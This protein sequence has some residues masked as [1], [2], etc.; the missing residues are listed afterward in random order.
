MMK[1]ETAGNKSATLSIGSNEVTISGEVL[2][3][4]EV[5]NLKILVDG[6]EAS[7]LDFGNVSTN[8]IKNI[9]VRN[10]GLKITPSVNISGDY[11]IIS[12]SCI[13]E[14]QKNDSCSIKVLFSGAGKVAGEYLGELSVSS[15]SLDLEAE[16]SSLVVVPENLSFYDGIVEIEDLDLGVVQKGHIKNISIKNNNIKESS[17]LSVNLSSPEYALVFDSCS[18]KSLKGGHSCLLKI[19]VVAD[20]DGLYP[21]NLSVNDEE[22]PVVAIVGASIVRITL[23]K[24]SGVGIFKDSNGILCDLNCTTVE[25]S[26]ELNS[27]LDLIF[28]EA[29]THDFV[30]YGD[31]CAS[32]GSSSLNCDL[33]V[34]SEATVSVE[35][36]S[37]KPIVNEA[38]LNAPAN[39][40]HDG[41]IYLKGRTGFGVVSA[42]ISVSDTRPSGG[43]ILNM[44]SVNSDCSNAKTSIPL[45]ISSGDIDSDNGEYSLYHYAED[46]L[47][48]RS[49]CALMRT[50]VFDNT[51][52]LEGGL[53]EE[54]GYSHSSG[55][56]PLL[57]VSGLIPLEANED[58]DLNLNTISLKI[59]TIDGGN[60][61]L[62]ET[63]I[64]PT[65]ND[66]K[67]EIEAIPHSFVDNYREVHLS[68]TIRDKAMN[69]KVV[70]TSYLVIN[71]MLSSC[72][73]IV[74]NHVHTSGKDRIYYID[75]DYYDGDHQPES[76]YCDMTRNSGGWELVLNN[77]DNS[78]SPTPLSLIDNS[79]D[80]APTATQRGAKNINIVT[81]GST[82]FILRVQSL[83]APDNVILNVRENGTR[84]IAPENPYQQTANPSGTAWTKYTWTANET[85][86]S[87]W[88]V[89]N[90]SWLYGESGWNDFGIGVY[91]YFANG[92]NTNAFHR[93]FAIF[94]N[95]RSSYY[96]N[97][98]TYIGERLQVNGTYI[99]NDMLPSGAVTLYS[100]PAYYQYPVNCDDA[101]RRGYP[102]GETTI[103]VDGEGGTAPSSVYCEQDLDGGGW[104]LVYHA[105][106]SN[107]N[108][109][110]SQFLPVYSTFP[111][112]KEREILTFY[113]GNSLVSIEP[114]T[115]PY[116]F[117]LP[118]SK[119]MNF[120]TQTYDSLSTSI[121]NLYT[122]QTA[123]ALMAWGYW[124][125]NFNN[126]C[127]SGFWQTGSN[128]G[129]FGVAAC[130]GTPAFLNDF[131]LFSG[132]TRSS[133]DFCSFSSQNYATTG[134]SASRRMT[135]FIREK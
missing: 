42:N 134:C 23:V 14:L 93:R 47:G 83:G 103:D 90:S 18:G 80:D 131:P 100:K 36:K 53:I 110:T 104:T 17:Q 116:K 52:P 35:V 77:P 126:W 98:D 79:G 54:L 10:D 49:D 33:I 94:G 128:Y 6:Q 135:M 62:A 50:I 24:D 59:G 32:V 88:N 71:N 132:F 15:S 21:L 8:L 82:H 58:I 13:K 46:E 97:G 76:V 133:N 40:T 55:E 68:L 51:L 70:K 2:S 81:T 26:R 127:G 113:S 16:V 12:T 84:F 78:V 106:T 9:V 96:A 119:V 45:L 56:T 114:I 20:N 130:T 85:P 117:V 95:G 44:V 86:H 129:I 19:L 87:S 101:R 60:D 3:S 108:T 31:F 91:N 75:R 111:T 74:R 67:F 122:D 7:F 43:I 123:T 29:S 125:F 105:S 89:Q 92:D 66:G 22:L 118:A 115:T 112:S 61:I 38:I 65:F 57:K 27:N 107:Y 34:L 124:D 25:I 109:T 11:S 4:N 120:H 48:N 37:S 30:S 99:S 1:T 39:Q 72:H 28:E 73:E 121:T 5:E 41:K 64:I 69:E 63:S 102:S